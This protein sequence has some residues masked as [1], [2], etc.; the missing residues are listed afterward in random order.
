MLDSAGRVVGV[1]TAIF[2][3]TG[4][5]AGIG[6]AIPIDT[7]RRI[8]P[9]LIQYGRVV[10]P[11]LNIQ[12]SAAHLPWGL[13][14]HAPSHSGMDEHA[15]GAGVLVFVCLFVLFSTCPPPYVTPQTYLAVMQEH[16]RT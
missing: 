3:N 5:S 15:R 7:V 4:A 9:Q 16:A 12:V 10:Q 11:A 1:N 13:A 2:T 6:F 14:R 8:V